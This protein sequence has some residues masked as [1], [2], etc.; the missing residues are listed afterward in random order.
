MKL[1]VL[2]CGYVWQD[3]LGRLAAGEVILGD[4][5][6]VVTLEKRGYV[7]SSFYIYSTHLIHFSIF[8]NF[9]NVNTVYHRKKPWT[10]FF[11]SL[12]VFLFSF[13]IFFDL[14]RSLALALRLLIRPK[15][16]SAKFFGQV[17]EGRKLDP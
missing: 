4:G 16:R 7:V 14:I 11:H 15:I 1:Y 5:S 17:C 13:E 8:L 12:L 9:K 6:Y 3:I 2:F 10:T